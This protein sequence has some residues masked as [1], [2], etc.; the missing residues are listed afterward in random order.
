MG[1]RWALFVDAGWLFAGGTTAAFGVRRQRHEVRWEPG[2]LVER[3]VAASAALVPADSEL[4]RTYWYDGSPRRLPVGDQV[5][6]AALPDVKLRLGR[7]G[8]N[9]QKGVDGL[10]IH[11]LITLA[12]AGRITDAVLLSGDEDLLEAVES[13]Q[14]SGAR[15]HLLEIPIGG[16]APALLNAVDRT[17]RLDATFWAQHLTEREAEATHASVPEADEGPAEITPP[18]PDTPATPMRVPSL[19]PRPAV[20]PAWMDEPPPAAPLRTALHD[21]TE[22]GAEFARMWAGAA[23]PDDYA[24]LLSARPYLPQDLDAQLLRAASKGAWLE[25]DECRVLRDAFWTALLA[26]EPGAADTSEM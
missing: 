15:V 5:H 16:I 14:A 2:S 22:A 21:L 23:S 11:D 3:L 10:I 7:T 4:L 8:L 6:V 1:G 25:V 24:A 18:Q 19:P 13:A 17:T 26:A 20:R 9:G 12:L